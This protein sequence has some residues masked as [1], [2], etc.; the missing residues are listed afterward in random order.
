MTSMVNAD[1]S[2]YAFRMVVPRSILEPFMASLIMNL[3]YAYFK[4][5][6]PYNDGPRHESYFKCWEMMNGRGRRQTPEVKQKEK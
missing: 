6:I 2:D 3:D 1:D 4:A 5:T